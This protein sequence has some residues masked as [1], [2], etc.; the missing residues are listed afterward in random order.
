MILDVI[1]LGTEDCAM[2]RQYNHTKPCKT[3]EGFQIMAVIIFFPP[4]I[5]T[6][7]LVSI[8]SAGEVAL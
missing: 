4:C 3:I 5:Y 6:Q 8:T 7:V 2:S 1:L